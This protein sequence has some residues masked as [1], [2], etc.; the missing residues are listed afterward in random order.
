VNVA[1]TTRIA[2]SP[3]GMLHL[4][5]ART[6]LFCW[7]AA[8]ASAGRFMLRID[9]TDRAR[10]SAE[11][12]APIY[13]GLEWLGLNY[14]LHARQS[15]R[16]G[17]YAS[18]ADKL[19]SSGLA[20]RDEGAVRLCVPADIVPARW[21]DT[22]GG[23]M[24]VGDKDRA[25]A[26]DLVLLRSDGSPTY[27]FASVVD[28][29]E[30]GV[31]WV[32]RGSDHISNTPRQMALWST[33]AG[34]DWAGSGTPLPL[35]SHVGLVTHKGTNLSKRDGAAS[36]LSYRDAGVHP[37]AMCN[38]LLR[39]GWGP[40]VDDRTARVIDRERAVALFLTGGRMR[41]SPAN[42]DPVLL[43]SLDRRYRGR[44]RGLQTD[45]GRNPAVQAPG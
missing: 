11:A 28:D 9:D 18:V 6:A 42:M 37:E 24:K 20:R 4:G 2:P 17:I 21:Q 13:E 5:T 25:M 40:S 16:L 36:L 15:D 26:A 1:H 39:L 22:V 32:I 10:N 12:V 31:T 35:W 27:H 30:F 34:I 14:D 7:L 8:R 23:T 29:M 38:F 41:P 44:D 19:L 43:A 3:T 45:A 33:L